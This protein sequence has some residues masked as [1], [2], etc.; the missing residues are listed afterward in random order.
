MVTIS[1]S[2]IGSNGDIISLDS[3]SDF[4][5]TSGV[6]GFGM[7]A[8]SVRIDESAANGGVWRNTKRGIREIDLPITILGVSRS[9]VE[10]KLRRLSRLI[11]DHQGPTTIRAQY[12]TGE[13]WDIKGHY[14]GGAESQYG[15]SGNENWIQWTLS[16]QCPDP[17]WVRNTSESYTLRSGATGRSLIPNLA[18]LRVSSSQAI[19]T[20]E[21]ENSGDVESYPRWTLSGPLN[22]ISITSALGESWSYNALI[23][24]GTTITVDTYSA[25]VTDHL[26]VNK[27]SN[28]GAAPKLFTIPSGNTSVAVTA[29]DATANS[30]ISMFFQPRKEVLH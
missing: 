4:V 15:D 29:T 7:P 20:F 9:D 23:P 17:F 21:V 25:S 27:Y 3:T 22:N 11:S 10:N 30:S 6:T 2:L 24:L 1:I 5:L 26:S 18:E 19:G 13:T 12:A 8:T 14:V 28:L 16:M